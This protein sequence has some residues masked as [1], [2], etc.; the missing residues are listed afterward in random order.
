[1]NI[2]KLLLILLLILVLFSFVSVYE[3]FEQKN[4]IIQEFT[5]RSD[6]Q[7]KQILDL[8]N[9]LID[10]ESKLNLS[11]AKLSEERAQKETFVQELFELKKTAKSNYAIIGV[12]SQG[13][14]AVIP[15]EVIIKSGNGS[16]FVDVANVLF[17]ETLQSSVQ[18]AVKVA[19]KITKINPKEKDILIVIHAPVSSERSEIGGGSGGAAMTIAIIAAIE[20]RN[21]SK[22]V[23]ITGT[24]EEY[25]TIGKVGAVKEKGM[26]AK[27]FGAKKFIVPI[28]QNVSIQDLEVK[29]VF[30]ID[31][32]LKYI[33]PDSS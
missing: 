4:R 24:I 15:L 9:S 20:G 31:D 23:L 17:D 32:A 13:K 7:Q 30:L 25:H 33:I 26:A 14:G 21:I 11:E 19:S 3:K 29:E 10:L 28:G 2:R 1:M 22:D 16:L 8:K 6:E 5:E 18:T 12:D 27:E